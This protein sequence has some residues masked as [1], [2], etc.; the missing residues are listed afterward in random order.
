[1]RWAT[2]T[3]TLSTLKRR[4]TA[5]TDSGTG[6]I[7]FAEGRPAKL[8]T[9][10][11]ELPGKDV[12]VLKVE[13]SNMATIPLGD[14]AALGTGDRLFV[15]GFPAAATFNPVLS[16]DSQK[17]PTLTQGVLSAKRCRSRW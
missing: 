14:D 1:V 4:L 3:A 11:K 13:A 8:V 2:K 9:A 6:G 15:L 10:G 5:L 16:K 12:A 17:E 7:T